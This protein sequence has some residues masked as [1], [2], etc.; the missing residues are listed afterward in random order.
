MNEEKSMILIIES[1]K[2]SI[3]E[4]TEEDKKLAILHADANTRLFGSNGLLDSMDVVI[5]LSDLEEKLDDDFGIIISLASDSAMSKAR[6]PF[7]SVK[8]LAKYISDLVIDG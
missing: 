5:L 8:S 2:E 1:L 4:T 3:D 6:S 7:R